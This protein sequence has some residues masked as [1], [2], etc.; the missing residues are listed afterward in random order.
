MFKGLFVKASLTI[1]CLLSSCPSTLL[2]TAGLLCTRNHT[3]VYEYICTWIYVC[4]WNCR[5]F[6]QKTSDFCIIFPVFKGLFSKD[7]LAT[8]F[9]A[10]TRMVNFNDQYCSVPDSS[11]F[12]LGQQNTGGSVF[13]FLRVYVSVW[14][15][16]LVCVSV[17]LCVRV[18]VCEWMCVCVCMR[19]YVYICIYTHV[20]AYILM[21]V[22][23]GQCV[24]WHVYTACCIWSVIISIS[25]LNL[26]D[27]F[28]TERVKGYLE[29]QIIVWD[30]RI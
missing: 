4:K 1:F 17:C 22:Y 2:E 18:N 11:W 16:V 26:L 30:L 6:V 13:V 14:L 29:N 5:S 10:N 24:G 9:G 8:F 7:V 12:F 20:Y 19:S 23:G 3:Y 27:L 21:C 15:C 28:S 25:N